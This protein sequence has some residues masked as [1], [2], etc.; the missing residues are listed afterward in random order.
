MGTID[1]PL[2]HCCGYF[3][4]VVPGMCC[5]TVIVFSKPDD[6]QSEIGRTAVSGFNYEEH[7][8]AIIRTHEWT[9]CDIDTDL[10]APAP[11]PQESE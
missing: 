7:A 10:D 9:P 6:W 2:H 5:P 4:A 11:Q 1:F 3:F 8:R